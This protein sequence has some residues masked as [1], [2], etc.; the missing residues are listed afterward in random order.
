LTNNYINVPHADGV[1][2]ISPGLPKHDDYSFAKKLAFNITQD[3]NSFISS[4]NYQVNS[5]ANNNKGINEP[6]GLLIFNGNNSDNLVRLHGR[7]EDF[8]V[9]EKL[10]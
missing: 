9:T 1:I 5:A 10:T 6:N 2:G 8:D 3:T 4:I 7:G